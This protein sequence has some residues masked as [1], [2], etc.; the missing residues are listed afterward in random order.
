MFWTL[1]KS[2]LRQHLKLRV[3]DESHTWDAI[4]FR[5]GDRV[6]EAASGTDIEVVYQMEPNTWNGRTSLQLVVEDFA[7]TS[8]PR[9][10]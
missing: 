5:Q 10:I 1:G 7:P 6:A 8:Q 3:A 2:A 9:L 4:A